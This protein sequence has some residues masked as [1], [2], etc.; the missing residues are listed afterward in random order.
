MAL[1]RSGV[2]VNEGAEWEWVN[3]LAKNIMKGWPDSLVQ[4]ETCL[5]RD[6]NPAGGHSPSGLVWLNAGLL[7]QAKTDIEVAYIWAV[8]AAKVQLGQAEEISTEVPLPELAESGSMRHLFEKADEQDEK[9]SHRSDS[10]AQAWLREIWP[11]EAV[12]AAI[13]RLAHP[14]DSM[15]IDFGALLGA[16]MT[17]GAGNSRVKIALGEGWDWG[18]PK[19]NQPEANPAGT[20]LPKEIQH[21]F[22]RIQVESLLMEGAVSKALFSSAAYYFESLD[23][24]MKELLARSMTAYASFRCHDSSPDQTRGVPTAF[25]NWANQYQSTDWTCIGIRVAWPNVIS[26]DSDIYWEQ[27]LTHLMERLR[28]GGF[29]YKH[30]FG[31]AEGMEPNR[32]SAEL[33]SD[34]GTDPLF[35]EMVMTFLE[36]ESDDHFNQPELDSK[37]WKN[38]ENPRFRGDESIRQGKV[39][40]M[41]PFWLRVIGDKAGYTGWVPDEETVSKRKAALGK[42]VKAAGMQ[43]VFAGEEDGSIIHRVGGFHK[44]QAIIGQGV[45]YPYIGS[46]SSDL[47]ARGISYLVDCGAFTVSSKPQGNGTWFAGSLLFSISLPGLVPFVVAETASYAQKTYFFEE[48]R[49]TEDLDIVFNGLMY[50][51]EKDRIEVI[52]AR[53][54]DLFKQLDRRMEGVR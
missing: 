35:R 45:P 50:V 47:E 53:M 51:E 15:E 21:G 34:F 14:A 33:F 29:R 22:R 24:P 31:G 23:P 8:H 27:V 6:G 52:K 3:A 11:E 4:P 13:S 43:A 1:L 12:Q 10:M 25:L 44:W 30:F 9:G 7:A 16:Q 40:V 49:S 54:Y 36:G 17:K 38:D 48:V 42:A 19:M 18:D 46:L 5:L 26:S 2:V 39:L 32:E 41:H 20:A 37:I 28:Q